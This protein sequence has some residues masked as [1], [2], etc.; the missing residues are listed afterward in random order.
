MKFN[1]SQRRK[2]GALKDHEMIS[3]DK[4]VFNNVRA[5]REYTDL[6]N[7]L[8]KKDF[9]NND[10]ILRN[11]F[12]YSFSSGKNFYIIDGLI[13]KYPKLEYLIKHFLG[14]PID[15]TDSKYF[16]MTE[17]TTN[18][19]FNI[20]FEQYENA[21]LTTAT[22]SLDRAHFQKHLD[23]CLQ[24]YLINQ[25][26]E[27]LNN[28]LFADGRSKANSNL[29]GN[30]MV[31]VLL[32][33]RID[34]DNLDPKG[35]CLDDVLENNIAMSPYPIFDAK[36]FCKEFGTEPELLY[37]NNL[38]ISRDVLLN[39][40]KPKTPPKPKT[41]RSGALKD[42]NALAVSTRSR[43]R[44]IQRTSSRKRRKSARN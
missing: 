7:T 5:E 15:D 30:I 10:D 31:T 39:C 6:K 12:Q 38:S 16:D 32:K 24:I 44:S 14:Y 26:F 11:I 29:A 23:E 35:I 27:G 40:E 37:T 19:G 21:A 36:F 4:G 34:D 3:F 9:F 42:N 8:K 28:T 1:K 2:G 22:R 13:K 33:D 43:K 41:P 18:F 17:R 20:Y 25:F